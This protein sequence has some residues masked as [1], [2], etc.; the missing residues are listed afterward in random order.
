[1]RSP[2]AVLSFALPCHTTHPLGYAMYTAVGTMT[3][4]WAKSSE[5][6]HRVRN[7]VM[8]YAQEPRPAAMGPVGYM[9]QQWLPKI[10]WNWSKVEE[11]MAATPGK[12]KH[13]ERDAV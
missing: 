1:M 3:R 6:L 12:R 4:L 5:H 10:K 8:I 7:L 13:I 9:L 2:G 11:A